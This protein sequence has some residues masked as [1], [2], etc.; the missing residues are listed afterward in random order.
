VLLKNNGG[1]LPL[2]AK[3]HV[4]VAGAA[5]DDIGQ[6]SGGWSI[7]WQGTGNTNADFPHG[8]SIWSGLKDAISAGGGVAELAP[9]GAFKT[10][11]DVAIVVFG[12]T[13]YA[14]FQGDI[15]TVEYTPGNKR[16]L[17]LLKRLRAQGIPAVAV[18]LS[19]RPLWTNPEINASEAF[20]A[21][22]LPGTEGAGIADVLIR[23][24]DG[25]VNH[26]FRGKLSYSWPRSAVQ[27][28]L[29][30][31]DKNYDPQ[32]AYGYGLTYRDKSDLAALSEVSG[33]TGAVAANTDLF[34]Q[35]GHALAPW[36][37]RV[38]DAKGAADASTGATTSPGGALS[39]KPVDA[40]AQESARTVQWSGSGEGALVLSG[41]ATDLVRQTNGDMAIA[42]HYRIERKAEAPVRIDLQCNGA[43]CAS[44]DASKL[45]AAAPMG[46]WRT[47]K[48]KLSCFRESSPDL[49]KVTAPFVLRT[50][51][52][53]G[54]TFTDVSLVANT[55]DALCLKGS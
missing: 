13:P 8:Q 28:P 11:P 38:A 30:V 34:F 48:I 19:G 44:L 4:L 49:S 9:D 24:P 10:K 15:P 46:E 27:T 32:F 6:A 41:P 22:W 7:S 52:P 45:F 23:K 54:L 50:G 39:I 36:T 51:G 31:G 12:E 1:L 21:A 47:V 16:D 55:G 25:A 20:V 43:T 29:N 37:L 26:D 53:F 14:E 35:K 42:L 40:G 33:V 2:S 3:A 18:F 17:A 5:A